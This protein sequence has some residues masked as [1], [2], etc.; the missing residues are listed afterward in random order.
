VVVEGFF[1]G[2]GPFRRLGREGTGFGE[3]HFIARPHHASDAPDTSVGSCREKGETQ[4]GWFR[5][6]QVRSPDILCRALLISA[7]N[8]SCSG[9]AKHFFPEKSL[10][11]EDGLNIFTAISSLTASGAH[12]MQEISKLTFPVSERV[13]FYARDFTGNTDADSLLCFRFATKVRH[14]V[15]DSPYLDEP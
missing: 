14:F 8:L 7:Q 10:Q 6:L 5:F 13:D 12:R 9:D 1:K 11:Q 2:L 15:N 4:P 3:K